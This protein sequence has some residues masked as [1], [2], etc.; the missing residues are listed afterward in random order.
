[1]GIMIYKNCPICEGQPTIKTCFDGYGYFIICNTCSWEN[2]IRNVEMS[3]N[4]ALEHWND[5]IKNYEERMNQWNN[6]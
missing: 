2:N 5:K 3:S 6:S 1:M 4:V